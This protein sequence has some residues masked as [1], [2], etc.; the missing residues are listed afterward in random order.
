MNRANEQLTFVDNPSFSWV[1]EA[2]GYSSSA[3]GILPP[4]VSQPLPRDHHLYGKEHL[5]GDH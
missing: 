1:M 5:D 3:E 4:A 2:V